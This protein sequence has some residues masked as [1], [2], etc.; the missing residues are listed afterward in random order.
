VEVE[1]LMSLRA[2]MPRDLGRC[3][4]E[5]N[6][7]E[8]ESERMVVGTHVRI[9]CVLVAEEEF[10]TLSLLSRWKPANRVGHRNAL[11]A[12]VRFPIQEWWYV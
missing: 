5:A 11:L 4:G 7:A 8:L 2:A 10:R 9:A 1:Q 3:E 12:D 6:Q